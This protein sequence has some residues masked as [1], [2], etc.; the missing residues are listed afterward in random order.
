[1]AVYMVEVPHEEHHCA[2]SMHE[3][4]EFG[5]EFL[6]KWDWGCDSGV[7]TGWAQIEATSEA[8]ARA[9]LPQAFRQGA[10]VVEINKAKI[11]K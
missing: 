3:M 4:M 6:A 10:R 2:P 7:H 8:E 9:M 11:I 1:M 5:P